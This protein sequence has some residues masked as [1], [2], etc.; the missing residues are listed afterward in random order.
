M[1]ATLFT[2]PYSGHEVL[3][4]DL[5]GFSCGATYNPRLATSLY[6]W[7][8][9]CPHCQ[10]GRSVDIPAPMRRHIE[11]LCTRD[12]KSKYP[13]QHSYHLYQAGALYKIEHARIDDEQIVDIM[14][15]EALIAQVKKRDLEN[16]TVWGDLRS[17]I[18]SRATRLLMSARPA[19]LRLVEAI[20]VPLDGICVERRK[21][22]GRRPPCYDADWSGIL[23]V[24]SKK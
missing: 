4:L 18:L 9:T 17:K 16:R 12:E 14:T 7:K 24:C 22:S 3:C 23:R 19:D 8:S 6:P 2:D 20:A 15:G 13:T 5:D 21:K 11:M 1:K 10:T